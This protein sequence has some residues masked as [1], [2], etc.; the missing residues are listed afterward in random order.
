[1]VL[2]MTLLWCTAEFGSL[3]YKSVCVCFHGIC[4]FYRNQWRN[5][6]GSRYS[7]VHH[8]PLARYVKLWLRMRRECRERFTRHRT[9][10]IPTCIT[11]LTPADA[12]GA[13]DARP[14]ARRVLTAKI[15]MFII[16]VSGQCE[17]DNFTQ[18]GQQDIMMFFGIPVLTWPH[19]VTHPS[20]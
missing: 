2:I 19:C 18:N 5:T 9:L 20:R 6:V 11:A 15:A 13:Y 14:S 1:M 10:E 8:G 16:N 7:I 3:I 17:S 4:I 12:V